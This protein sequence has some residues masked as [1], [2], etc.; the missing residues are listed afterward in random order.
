MRLTL[1]TVTKIARP[2][3]VTAHHA[4]TTKSRLKPIISPQLMTFGSPSPRNE[5]P[6]S[7]RI[8]T[9]MVRV[10]ETMR[11]GRALGRITRQMRRR[12][13]APMARA[14]LTYSSSLILRNSA[15]VSRATG[16]QLTTPMAMAMVVRLWLNRLTSTIA[17]S[18]A[19]STWKNSVR[20]ISISST[21]PP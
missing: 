14:A 15:R 7:N 5:S 9:P 3:K 10:A 8:A 4:S 2:G 1:S 21:K 20:R 16:G 19:G 12:L 13:R 6:A 11:G 18:R 17:N